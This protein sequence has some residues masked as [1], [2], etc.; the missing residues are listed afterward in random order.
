[1][2]VFS[3]SPKST[4]DGACRRRSKGSDTTT[5]DER[6]VCSQIDLGVSSLKEKND[7]HR[8]VASQYDRR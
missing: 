4:N 8:S 1:M 5:Y 7:S 3:L 6:K 2:N